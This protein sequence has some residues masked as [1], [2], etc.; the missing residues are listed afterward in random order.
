M[1]SLESFAA[2]QARIGEFMMHSLSADP[3]SDTENEFNRLALEVFAL[4]FDHNPPFAALCKRRGA[5]PGTVHRWEAVPAVP[6]S[7]FKSFE[8]TCLPHRLRVAAFHSSGTTTQRASRHFH[9][10]QS[11]ALYAASLDPWFCR[12]VLPNPRAAT[13]NS[14]SFVILTPPPNLAPNS[15]L[16]HMLA[17]VSARHGGDDSLFC[18]LV[19]DDAWTLD[20]ERVIGALDQAVGENRPVA[21]LGTA[22]NFVH[23]TD[24]L[25]QEQPRRFRL[26]PGSRVMETGGYKGRSR[27]MPRRELHAAITRALG[28]PANHIVC[29]YGMCELSSQAYDGTAGQIREPDRV[30]HFPPWCRARVV[31]PE[32]GLEVRE[33]ETGLLQVVDLA[34]LYSVMAVQ[35]GDLAARQGNGFIL[36]GRAEAQ[37]PR[38]CSLMVTDSDRVATAG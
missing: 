11:L 26:P 12:H 34:N 3:L 16:V 7:A 19:R 9:S 21:V 32:T 35:T 29:E 20:F 33:N 6:T 8:F 18:G 38:G 2:L 23:L 22:F 1:K 37:E 31:S 14:P 10:A 4:Q 36:R 24:F 27:E 17:A 28:V 13:R 15:S 5:L 30:F 25:E